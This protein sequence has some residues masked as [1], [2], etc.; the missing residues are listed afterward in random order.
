LNQITEYFLGFESKLHETDDKAQEIKIGIMMS[1][2]YM[3]KYILENKAKM[4][5]Q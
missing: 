4:K 1:K 2:N 3:E 5:P